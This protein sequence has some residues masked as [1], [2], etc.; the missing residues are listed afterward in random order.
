MSTAP[1]KR[2]SRRPRPES[3]TRRAGVS[4]SNP[5]SAIRSPYLLP[6]VL[7]LVILAGIPFALGKYFEFSNPDPFDGGSYAYSA[8]H[9]LSG[10]RLG[11]D[12]KPSAQPGTLLVNVLG[13]MM[14]G[15][16]ETGAKII[17]MLLQAAALVL[18]FFTIRRLYGGLAAVVA[19]VVASVYLSAPLLAKFGNVKEQYMIAFMVMAICC[20]VLYELTGKWW[21]A[22]LAGAMLLWGPLFKQTGISAVIAVGLFV[23]AQPLLRHA[24]WKKLGR[25]ILLLAAGGVA[26]LAPLYVWYASMRAPLIYWPYMYVLQPLFS[27]PAA[28]T[29]D[30]AGTAEPKPAQAE[31]PAPSEQP[32]VGLVLSL[33]P[34][35]VRDSW[36]ILDAKARTEAV[37]RVFRHYRALILPIALA[38]GALAV[39]ILVLLRGKRVAPDAP[40]EQ[41]PGRFVPLFAVWWLF[42]MGFIFISPH[43]YEQ[44]YLPLNASSAMLGSYLVGMY[45]QKL[46]GGRDRNR[47]RVLGLLGLVLMIAMSWH[48]F[49]GVSRSPY[50]GTPY[51]RPSR[52]YLQKWQEVR[53]D[54]QYP[55]QQVGRYIRERSEPNDV[56]YVWGWVPGIYVEAQRMSSAPKAFEGTM[57]TLA[58]R[59][60]AARVREIVDA[61]EKRPPKFIVDSRKDHFPWNRPPM[62]LWP[63]APMS[64]GPGNAAFLPDDENMVKSYDEMWAALLTQHFG[65]DEAERYRALAPLRQYVRKHYR[66][67]EPQGYRA[68]RSHGLPTLAHTVFEMNVVLVRK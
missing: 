22:V 9:I 35:Y 61:F 4:A 36:L 59:V 53:S 40:M 31:P 11:Y 39:R 38:L 66:V 42:D 44:Y 51:G 8:K 64:G 46:T 37:V 19:V 45:T 7:A 54:P 14:T 26:T 56:I 60:L 25:D 5:P 33:L 23:L 13:V 10:A 41:D 52:G 15:F 63:I 67:A 47:W 21:W 55:W 43:S 62:E 65:P 16:N 50:S 29:P 27:H 68:V 57:H 2:D 12:E 24:P 1:R 3:G 18:M 49:F 58:P 32:K 6:T 30:A 48:I 20:F 28:P 34:G 17:Q